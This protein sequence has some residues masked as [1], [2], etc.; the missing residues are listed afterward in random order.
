MNDPRFAYSLT[1]DEFLGEFATRQLAMEAAFAAAR[2]LPDP[3]ACVYVA[4]RVVGNPQTD[5][6]ALDVISEMRR[7]A[8]SQSGDLADGYLAHVGEAQEADLDQQI[9]RALR[10]WLTRHNL[11]PGWFHARGISE[12]PVPAAGDVA[13]SPSEDV[14]VG[15]LGGEEPTWLL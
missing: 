11:G 14:S 7:R 10:E 8:F 6:H 15:G 4:Q 3:P 2:A 9:N 12:H 1:G 13:I 5:G